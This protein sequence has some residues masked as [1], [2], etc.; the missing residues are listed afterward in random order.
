MATDIDVPFTN[1]SVDPSADGI[2]NAG[3]L[4]AGF[5]VLAVTGAVG[6]AVGNR[7]LSGAAEA[8]GLENP[9]DDGLTVN[10]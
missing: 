8:T 2:K 3:G 1:T 6:V 4:A 7:V 5:A 10:F 9:N